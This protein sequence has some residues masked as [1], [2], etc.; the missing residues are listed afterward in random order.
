MSATGRTHHWWR[1]VTHRI[2]IL[3]VLLSIGVVGAFLV[4]SAPTA[5]LTTTERLNGYRNLVETEARWIGRNTYNL[6]NDRPTPNNTLFDTDTAR[7]V[8]APAGQG[9]GYWKGAPGTFYDEEEEALYLYV[10]SRDPFTRGNS[11]SI[12]RTHNGSSFEN[13]WNISRRSVGAISLEGAAI[14]KQENGNYTL[15]LSY[16]SADTKQWNIAKL[17]ARSPSTFD[18]QTRQDLTLPDY[19]NLKDPVI[20]NEILFV[21]ALN[22][23][24]TSTATVALNLSSNTPEIIGEVDFGRDN[25]LDPRLTSVLHL[26]G[27]TIVFYDWRPTIF[28]T[29]EEMSRY[30]YLDGL[31][32]TPHMSDDTTFA[33]LKGTGAL[34]YISTE[35]VKDDIWFFY[36]TS[37]ET[38]DH[39]L[40]LNKVPQHTLIDQIS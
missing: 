31:V 28:H 21:H 3:I 32:A 14:H 23:Y 19:R 30:G 34:R 4:Q 38:G 40:R 17:D 35:N 6:F 10:R 16:Q 26:S 18:P 22:P 11:A 37:T 24:Y 12:W 13:V 9:D 25:D 1:T 8:L 36:E 27:K 5:D 20:H 29:G 15:Y 7:V 33:S 39:V 2:R